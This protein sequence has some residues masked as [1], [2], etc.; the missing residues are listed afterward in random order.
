[1]RR[2]PGVGERDREPWWLDLEMHALPRGFDLDGRDLS[3]KVHGHCSHPRVPTWVFFSGRGDMT[4]LRAAQTV[5][6][7]CPVKRQCLEFALATNALG[8]WAGTTEQ[9]R[10][11]LRRR[12]GGLPG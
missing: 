2:L 9:Y 3:W 7:G 8:V 5:C 6:A 11:P 12:R 4:T 1:V 10:Q